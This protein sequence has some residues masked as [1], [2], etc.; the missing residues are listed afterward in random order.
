MKQHHN[1]ER[2]SVCLNCLANL[3]TRGATYRCDSIGERN[4]FLELVFALK[5]GRIKHLRHHPNY[6]LRTRR[7]DGM[8]VDVCQYQADSEYYIGDQ[9]VVEDFKPKDPK[10]W[11]PVFAVK[12]RWFEAQE[13]IEITIKS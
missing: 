13:G 2:P 7:H 4:R 5:A 10:S 11:D 1:N 12:K 8:T 3:T 9:R 6:Q